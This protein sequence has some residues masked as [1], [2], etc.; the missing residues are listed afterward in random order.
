M[1]TNISKYIYVNDYILCEYEFN[2]DGVQTSLV[3]PEPYLGITSVDNKQ[4]YN[5]LGLGTTNNNFS[6]NSVPI[7]SQRSSWY[8]NSTNPEYLAHYFDSSTAISTTTYPH[9]T[10]K[11][12]IISGYNFDDTAGFLFQVQALDTSYNYVDLSNFTWAKQT[13]I[14]PYVIHFNP[15]VLFLGNKFYDKYIEFKVPCVQSLGNDTTSDIGTKLSI[16]Q[17][18]DIYFSYSNILA[19]TDNN[20]VLSDITSFQL[21]VTSAADSFNAFISES[22]YGDYIEYYATWD[23]QIIGQYMGD[24]ESN[25]I[26]LYTSNTPNDNYQ[27]F[28]DL[29]GNAN[30]WVLMHE[31]YVY[32]NIPGP[33]GGSS[34]LTQKFTFTQ[35]DNFNYANYFRPVIKNADIIAS[36]SINYTVRLLN[37][38][39]GTQIIRKAAFTS[40]NPKKYGRTLTRLNTNNILTYNI[41][42]KISGETTL[43][44]NNTNPTETKYIRQFYDVTNIMLNANGTVYPQGTGPLFLKNTGA[45][46]IFDFD[47]FDFL[48]RK[49]EVDLS[50]TSYLLTFIL[51]DGTI[52]EI[53]QYENSSAILILGQIE[54]FI[55]TEQSNR[56]LSQTNNNYSIVVQNIDGSKFTFYEGLYYSNNNMQAV[57]LTY[58]NLLKQIINPSPY[59]GESDYSGVVPNT[60]N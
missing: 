16:Q 15:T 25:R 8:F 49:S 57:L 4:Y 40:T 3:T 13:T 58:A 39:D 43:D 17:S 28:S 44:I 23:N 21:P 34:I 24:I 19:I 54:F 50:S 59:A 55:S 5:K 37:R 41:F 6:L 29:Y 45:S 31:I 60:T 30:K 14:S 32:E 56:I 27:E 26:K 46:Y 12:H 22:T 1:S 38:M 9:D 2:K 42:N 7:N 11:L 53:P 48:G 10:I 36:Y 51:D 33:T 47:K 35:E 18:S 52:I 20:Y